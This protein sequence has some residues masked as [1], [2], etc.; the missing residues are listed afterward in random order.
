MALYVQPRAS[1]SEVVGLHGD[2]IK[3]RIAAPPVDGAANVELIGFL[4]R[5][6]RVP[7]SSITLVTGETGRTKRIR[8]AGLTPA[9]LRATLLG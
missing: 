3:M 9:T 6:L 5:R 8:V 7:K 4:A 1:K 2:A